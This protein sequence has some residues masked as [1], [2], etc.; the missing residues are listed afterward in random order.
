MSFIAKNNTVLF[1]AFGDNLTMICERKKETN[2][3]I[4]YNIFYGGCQASFGTV[5]ET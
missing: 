2:C 4:I 3:I 1:E 5:V